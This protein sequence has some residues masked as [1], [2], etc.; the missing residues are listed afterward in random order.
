MGFYGV[1]LV[2]V[3]VSIEGV[4][5]FK[6]QM[7][8]IAEQVDLTQ[9][10]VM[11]SV[12]TGVFRGVVNKTPVDTGRAR[13]SWRIGIGAP[14]LS[15]LPPMPRLTGA[16]RTR[17]ALSGNRAMATAEALKQLDKLRSLSKGDLVFITNSVPY[18]RY[19]EEGHSRQAPRGIVSVTLAEVLTKL[20]FSAKSGRR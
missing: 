12:S 6:R 14:D 17:K 16:D 8:F 11:R 10:R 13:G 15:M 7:Q 19:L 9:L 4:P 2:P 5:E 1:R 20:T 18:V 3:R